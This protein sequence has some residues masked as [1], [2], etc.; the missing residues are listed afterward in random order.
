MRT[1]PKINSTNSS[2]PPS[3]DNKLTKLKNQAIPKIKG[4]LKAKSLKI[5]ATP[6][7]IECYYINSLNLNLLFKNFFSIKRK[8]SQVDI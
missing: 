2:K 5:V 8:S 1:E 4:T 7:P 6:V 3:T